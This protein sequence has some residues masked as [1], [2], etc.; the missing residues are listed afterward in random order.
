MDKGKDIGIGVKPP[1]KGCE[2]PNCPFHGK[3]KVRGKLFEATVL[4]SRMQKTATVEWTRLR[5][6]P[7]YER[8]EKARSRV[9]AHN[10]PCIKAGEGDTVTIAETR[11]LSKT[12]HFVIVSKNE[13]S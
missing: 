11:P 7:K 5:K 4:R 8:S 3:L 6:V 9:K 12:K 13:G 1:K 2:D 10:P